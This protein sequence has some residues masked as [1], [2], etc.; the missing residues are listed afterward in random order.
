MYEEPGRHDYHAHYYGLRH[1]AATT[2]RPSPTSRIAVNVGLP[3]ASVLGRSLRRVRGCADRATVDRFYEAALRPAGGVDDNGGPH[4]L[5][6]PQYDANYYAAYVLD[7]RRQQHR[8]R[9]PPRADLDFARALG[10]ADRR[11]ARDPRARA[12]DRARADRAA[13]GRDRR[14]ARV[15]VGRRRALPRARHLRAPLR[16]GARRHRHR[17]APRARRDRGGLEGLRD[18]RAHPRRAGAR[19][20]RAQARRDRRAEGALPPE[21]RLRARCSPRT[22]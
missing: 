1:D 3:R 15:P 16:R 4:G 2:S 13:R 12:H 14:V 5:R 11:A 9:L 21:A 19:L 7:R 17:D 18:E 6:P 20:A 22:R 10:A 8:G